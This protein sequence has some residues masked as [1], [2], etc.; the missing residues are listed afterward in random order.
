MLGAAYVSL[1]ACKVPQDNAHHVETLCVRGRSGKRRVAAH[2]GRSRHGS[3]QRH[4]AA[5]P[6]HAAAQAVLRSCPR[7]PRDA[8]AQ[9]PPVARV[10]RHGAVQPG[11]A[12]VRGLGPCLQCALQPLLLRQAGCFALLGSWKGLQRQPYPWVLSFPPVWLVCLGY[13]CSILSGVCIA[14][15]AA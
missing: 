13:F 3:A 1:C 6:G 5:L 7:Q 9:Q 2:G 12:V 4:A 8:G 10:Q 11:A 15:G 14:Y